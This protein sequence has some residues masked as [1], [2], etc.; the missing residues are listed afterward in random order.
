M[1][2]KSTQPSTDPRFHL[3]LLLLS[4]SV[5]L[6]RADS[7]DCQLVRPPHA[8]R[9]RRQWRQPRS[10]AEVGGTEDFLE[11][12]DVVIAFHSEALFEPLHRVYIHP[13]VFELLHQAVRVP[14]PANGVDAPLGASGD[15]DVE[16]QQHAVVAV[17]PSQ[18]LIRQ[19]QP[20]AALLRGGVAPVND[21]I[22]AAEEGPPDGLLAPPPSSHVVLGHVLPPGTPQP[23]RQGA[24][25]RPGRPGQHQHPLPLPAAHC[26][27]T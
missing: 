1:I 2:E 6:L 13:I 20:V 3:R 11:Q 23:P 5:A 24:L 4:P 21:N 15:G 17:T 27:G 19:H 16:V 14:F 10:C 18:H 22:V 25:P 12:A 7:Q 8:R 26:R 9:W